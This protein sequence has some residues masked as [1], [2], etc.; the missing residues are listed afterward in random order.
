MTTDELIKTIESIIARLKDSHDPE[1]DRIELKSQWYKLRDG[2]HVNPRAQNEFLKDLVALANAPGATSLIII[3]VDRT[4]D[5]KSSGFSQCGLRDKPDLRGLVIRHV[6]WPVEFTL[7]EVPYPMPDKTPIISVIEIPSSRSKPH[8]IRHY[9]SPSGQEFQNYIPIRKLTGTCSAS[10]GDLDAMYLDRAQIVPDY[11]LELS[12][13]KPRFRVSTA[14]TVLTIEFPFVFQNSGQKP[15]AIVEAYLELYLDQSA[16]RFRIQSYEDEA[17]KSFF[18]QKYLAIEP[19]K[20]RTLSLISADRIPSE[21]AVALAK[22]RN[23]AFV[24][25]CT[26]SSGHGYRSALLERSQ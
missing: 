13:H 2:E 7:H 22:N 12:A 18:E 10:R 14:P 8:V 19:G 25:S 9:V 1:D 11:A 21:H 6:D 26:D 16:A 24:V 5:V 4:G 17:G 15:I 20:M 23:A 3:G